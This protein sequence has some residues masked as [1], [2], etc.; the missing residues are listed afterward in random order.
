MTDT[1]DTTHEPGLEE[2]WLEHDGARLFAVQSGEGLPV[3]LLHGGLANH[4]ACQGFA[5][6]LAQR[7]RLITPDLRASG[8][9]RF[10]GT[11]TWDQLADDVAAWLSKLGLARAVIGGVSA[12]AG[13]AVRV[14]LR[15]PGVTA[16]LVVLHPAYAGADVGLTAAQQ[17]A[18][19]AMDAAGSRAVAEGVEV[20]L[21]LFDALSP[22]IRERA[23][24]V[25]ATYDPASVAATTRF[26]A[27]GAQP[28]ATAAELAAIA[29]PTLLVPGIDPYHPAE[30]AERYRRH[31]TRCTVREADAA[32]FAAAIA[33]FIE[34]QQVR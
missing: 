16:A 4:R 19:A 3:V 28:F 9:S 5:A 29:A 32:D 1:S 10:A 13:C 17:A 20:L 18:M 2:I 22:P 24:A 23:R 21:P 7:F 8:R 12:G 30:V 31:L 11:L 33:G 25:A 6:P 27:S 34:Q 14:A 26:F 15:H